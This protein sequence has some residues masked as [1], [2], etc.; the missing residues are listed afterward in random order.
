LPRTILHGV[1]RYVRNVAEDLRDIH[2][3][4]KNN[5]AKLDGLDK[6][7]N[8]QF[9]Q[10]SDWQDET[11]TSLKRLREDGGTTYQEVKGVRKEQE[12]RQ[13]RDE[14]QS[15]LTWLTPTDYT[16]QQHDFVSRRQAGTGQWLLD[17]AEFQAWLETDKQTLFCPGIP[18]AGKTILTSI[19]V[20][21]L[22]TRFRND[23]SIGIAYLYCNFRR[24]D[25]QKVDD[26]LASLL[27]QLSQERTFLP[28]SVETLY[29]KHK[30]KRTR[31]SFD[32]ISRTFQTVTAIFSKVFIIIDA[33]D[34]CRTT[35]G[36]QTRLLTEIFLAQAN[37]RANIFATSRFMPEVVEKFEGS[38]SLEIR[39]SEEDVRRYL[40]SHMFRLPAFVR[41]NP[42]LQEEINIGIVL[43][44]KGM[45]V[46]YIRIQDEALTCFKVPPCTALS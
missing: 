4:I 3:V 10:A 32:E 14:R 9:K 28:D 15:I 43:L 26:L 25:E 42:D 22:T 30:D 39:A 21:E 2:V 16:A 7:Q 17:S 8:K 36:C 5:E 33:L 12:D 24:Q 18:G 41:R 23:E 20:Q 13:Q 46:P 31:P 1:E 40:D 45:W 38:I 37:S 44:V 29:G 11:T 19:V 27:K 34:E 6:E 35:D